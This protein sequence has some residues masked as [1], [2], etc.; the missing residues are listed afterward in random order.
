MLRS[1]LKKMHQ[2]LEKELVPLGIGHAE[3]RLLMLIDDTKGSSQE[4]LVSRV[5]VDR[6]NVGRALK[7]LENLNCLERSKA[8]EDKRA[9][10]VYLTHRGLEIKNLIIEIKGNFEKTFIKGAPEDETRKLIELLKKTDNRINEKN[11][12]AVK[13]SEKNTET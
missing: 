1:T 2:I 6:S 11:Y 10:Q 12:L 4:E 8:T 3:A 5:E 9:Y 13:N 7:K